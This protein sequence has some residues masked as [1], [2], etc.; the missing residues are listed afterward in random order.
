MLPYP[1]PSLSQVQGGIREGERQNKNENEH[2]HPEGDLS[3]VESVG[4]RK[5]KRIMTCLFKAST[6]Q[7]WRPHIGMLNAFLGSL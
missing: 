6:K 1:S 4:I 5:D 2:Y 3:P 7:L